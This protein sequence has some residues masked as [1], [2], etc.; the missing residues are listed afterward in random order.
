M[1]YNNLNERN[2]YNTL[3][4]RPYHSKKDVIKNNTFKMQNVKKSNNNIHEIKKIC[5]HT[6]EIKYIDCNPRLN[7][8]LS[9]SLDGYINIYT[10]PKCKLVSV[11]KINNYIK[12]EEPLI[13]VVLISNP[14]PM[15]FCYND[16]NIFV[17]TINGE[18][19]NK[20]EKDKYINLYP[21][22]DKS[23]GLI[24]DNIKIIKSITG[25][26]INNS[27]IDLPFLNNNIL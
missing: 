6:K 9:Y 18:L 5:D 16:T 21:C 22:V 2:N 8:F 20:K 11:I 27:E 26:I 13:K 14:F 1:K 15:I 3:I 17:F 25:N 10:F 23:L 7:L 24:K 19:I 4:Y 12:E